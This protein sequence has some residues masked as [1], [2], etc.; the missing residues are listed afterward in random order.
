MPWLFP[1]DR[2]H[3]V[4]HTTSDVRYQSLQDI[5][6]KHNNDQLTLQVVCKNKAGSMQTED[7]S[8]YV[9]MLPSV[10]NSMTDS[11]SFTGLTIQLYDMALVQLIVYARVCMLYAS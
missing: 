7:L 6:D 11:D 9:V 5:R 2:P 1:E 8:N 10:A 3:L 4:L